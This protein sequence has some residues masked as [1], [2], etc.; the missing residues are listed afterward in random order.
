MHAF[1][2]G[3]ARTPFTRAFGE[4]VEL[5][6]IAL[7]VVAVQG[8][9]RRLELPASAVDALVWGGV[10][11]PPDSPNIGREI[12]LDAGLPPTVEAMTVSRACASGLQA[13][14]DGVAKIERGE[15]EVVIAGGGDSTSN[16]PLTMPPSLVRKAGPVAMKRGAGPMDWLKLAT[17]LSPG[18][19][20][21]PRKPRVAERSTGELMGEAAEKMAGRNQVSRAEQDAFALRSQQ[22]AAAAVAAGRFNEELVPVDLPRGGRLTADTLIRGDTTL[23]R[24]STLKP[25]F[26]R[27]GTITA[28]NATALTDGAA[29]VVLMSEAAA[30]RY[31]QP[32]LARFRSFAWVG[33]DPADQL[34]MGPA[35]A[36]PL[37]LKRAGLELS[38]VD[39]VELHEAFAAQV[40][41]VQRMLESE[42]FGRER[43]GRDGAVGTIHPERLNVHGGSL[44]LGHPFAATGARIA[45]TL[46]HELAQGAARTGLIGICAA[47]GLGA[48]AVMERGPGEPTNS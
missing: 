10:I 23:E 17:T 41:S 24:L 8:A 20:L 13:I 4:L 3:G 33:V 21:V 42:A 40:L 1:I 19:D 18:R 44:A 46:A 37:A 45:L 6:T 47:G 15:A 9:L 48:A 2:V 22:R 28:G 31:G 36:M 39:R 26:A 7:G 30:R 14:A 25:A 11:L 12:A 32:M 38:E 34:L 43:L 35:L 29:C 27:D 5:D 16:A